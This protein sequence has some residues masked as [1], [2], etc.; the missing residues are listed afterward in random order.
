[1]DRN[2]RQGHGNK[3]QGRV[4][5]IRYTI[6]LDIRIKMSYKLI[7]LVKLNSIL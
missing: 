1:M 5:M 3:C 7:S 2:R 4:L 6:K